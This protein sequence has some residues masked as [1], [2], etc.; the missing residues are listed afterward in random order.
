MAALAGPALAQSATTGADA[1]KKA[2]SIGE[3][4]VTGQRASLRSAQ[5]IK[6]KADQIVDS[7]TSVDIGALPD[8]SVTEA[9]QRIPGVT[10]SRT[11]DPRD[12]D[13]I[14]VEGSGVQIRGLSYV[15]S[16]FNG[17]D[18]F[19]AVKGR[20]LSFDDVPAELMA[21]V[22][23]YKN[24][25][26]D[27][28]EGGV[29][30]TVN[31]RTR[32]PFDQPGHLIGYS[33]DASYGDL[34]DSWKPTGSILLSDRWDTP[35]GEVGLLFDFADS[36]FESRTDTFSVDPF[37]TRNAANNNELVAG[38][39]VYVPGGFG[40][41][42]LVFNRE[43][44]GLD[45][46]AQWRPKD[47][48]LVTAQYLR[49]AAYATENEHAV[50]IDTGN[51]T[52]P[53]AGTSFTYNAAGDFLAGTITSASGGTG[54]SPDVI[55]DRFNTNHS[56]TSDAS[57]KVKWDVTD[58]LTLSADVQYV[59]AT[60][61]QMDF[62]L[63]DSLN[64]SIGAPTLDLRGSMPHVTWN[65][66]TRAADTALMADPANYYWDAAMDYHNHNEGEEWAER[67]D[68]S[69]TFDGD[70]LK[71]FRFGV[72]HTGKTATT[73]DTNFNWGYVTQ[74]WSGA[75]RAFLD[76]TGPTSAGN[77]L[78]SAV[79]AFSG[80]F[81]GQSLFSGGG[82]G[83]FYA[84]VPGFMQNFA[85]AST[86][87][88][89]AE[90]RAASCCGPW[91]PFNGN[92][93]TFTA[94]GFHA[95]VNYQREQTTAAYG[96]LNFGH[97]LDWRGHTIPM[98]GGVGVRVVDTYARSKGLGQ[99][100]QCSQNSTCL[101]YFPSDVQTFLNG[102]QDKLHGGRDYLSVLPSLN[103]RFQLQPRLYLRFAASKSIVRPDFVQMLPSVNVTGNAGYLSGG[104]CSK[105]TS[106][107]NAQQNC[108]YNLSSYTGNANLKP[109]RANSYD[110]SLEWYFSSTG[111]LSGAL[112][113]KDIYNYV[114]TQAHNVQ[115]TNNGLTETVEAISPFNLGHGTI[116]GFELAYQQYFDFLPGALKGI[117]VQANYTYVDSEGARNSAED[118]F[119]PA[120][121]ANASLKLPLEGLS[122]N[123]YNISGLYDYGP[124]SARLAY[125]WRERYLQTPT[126]ANINIPAW[127]DDYGQLDGSIFYT[128][129]P[130][131][132]VGV[133]AANLTNSISKILVSY[134]ATPSL[135]LTGHNWIA[136][137]RRFT[138]V[139][140]GQ[141]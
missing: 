9:I 87:I 141:F 5:T 93:S 39:A 57:I 116:D 84:G 101:Q 132:K 129:S 2:D 12:A 14:S 66:A 140:R 55:D 60:T 75:G 23:V 82:P 73:R 44:Q 88:E 113:H 76:G 64:G 137:D 89:A 94:N 136:A 10:I 24:P 133:E 128:F 86:A 135:G 78:P 90:N 126:A 70:W 100:E 21:G 120:Q 38:Q 22:D 6:M 81:Q 45:F 103:L 25:S 30:G 67:I 98:D 63:F 61:K 111:S 58:K 29:G 125:N 18:S 62:T 36:N 80:F 50:G 102:G 37:V 123:S 104:V 107:S 68:G 106:I 105:T 69:Y 49:S 119:D 97:D 40:Y 85:A 99:Y 47:N 8:R 79:P 16:E 77:G 56:V 27:L 83:G 46:A 96:L 43:R 31:L 139:V 131:L 7:I 115:L 138:F 20:S 13:R 124:V 32:L 118:P 34:A 1:A 65:S 42:S 28:I 41:R 52:G 114:T 53:A 109:T 95:G 3:V 127:S 59:R 122:R 35:I 74:S 11:T 48:L 108:F 54:V 15:R 19:S 121:S 17:R 117:G 33:V 51:S 112:F 91:T 4:V 26:A 110:V 71:S 92:Y 130:K 72:R 134:P